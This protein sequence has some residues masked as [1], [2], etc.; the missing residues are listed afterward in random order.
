MKISEAILNL[1]ARG[2]TAANGRPVRVYGVRSVAAATCDMSASE[3]YR[4]QPALRAVVS[5]LARNIAETPI[6]CYERA[7]DTDRLRDTTS[8]LAKLVASPS[9]GVTT[10]ELVRAVVSDYKLYDN[11]LLVVAPDRGAPSGWV[12]RSIPWSWVTGYETENGFEPSLYR[13]TNPYTGGASEFDAADCIHFGGYDPLG[14]MSESSPVEALRAVLSE[15]VSAWSFRNSVWRNGGRVTQYITR[16]ANAPDWTKNGGRD[17]FAKSWKERYAGDEGTN[18]GGTPLLEDGMELKT[19]SFNARESQ[20]EEATR[21]T[22]EDVAAVYHVP[23]ALVWHAD[24]QTYASAKDNARQLY[25]ETLG[26]DFRMLE[27]KLN[28][29][30]VERLGL[31]PETNYLEFDIGSKL[32]GSFEEQA[33]V[34]QSS[35]GGPWLTRNE[36]RA[37]LNLPAIDGGDELIVPLNVVE[38][39]LASPND[40][41]PTAARY[42]SAEPA[43][44][45]A[46]P[47]APDAEPQPT[48]LK[49]RGDPAPNAVDEM[50]DILRHFAERQGRSVLAAIEAYQAKDPPDGESPDPDSPEWWDAER[51]NRE[52]ADDLEPA[53]RN[54]ATTRALEALSDLRVPASSYDVA[55]TTA[56]LRSMAESRARAFNAVTLAA[57]LAALAHEGG[58]GVGRTPEGVFSLA[59]G[60]RAERSGH[61]FAGSASAFGTTEAARQAYPRDRD[62]IRRY[63]VWVHHPSKNPRSNHQAMDGERVGL[64]DRFSNGADWPGDDVLG[65]EDVCYCHCTV[66]VEIE[67][68]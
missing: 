66:E 61:S 11:A 51:W 7:S 25:T 64:D 65:P 6:K 13:V 37:R 68:D 47:G 63:K 27:Q 34:L 48:L 67:I 10:F 21:L 14:D 42:S 39:G 3:M 4:K 24:G 49:S 18:T 16:P 33:S 58:E 26:P 2:R 32:A 5:F 23:A 12:M 15:Q 9:P 41:D 31:D 55:R 53:F 60:S 46:P 35:T 8:D 40:T 52:L 50:T 30:L 62:G 56:F 17:R 38:G 45:E 20:W 43:T 44:K 36:A 54:W 19:T 57:L 1:Y 22:R 28:A 59:S 29:G